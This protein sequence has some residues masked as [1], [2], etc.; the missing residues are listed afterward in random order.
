LEAGLCL[1]PLEKLQRYPRSSRG[2]DTGGGSYFAAI[3]YEI[4][5][6]E[7]EGRWRR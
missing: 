7:W 3:E 4:E 6:S 5:R 1:E 2:G